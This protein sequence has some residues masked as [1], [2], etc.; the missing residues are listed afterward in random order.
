CAAYSIDEVRGQLIK[1]GLEGL[2]VTQV[3]DRHL[4]VSGRL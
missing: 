2:K 4:A 3:S 1:A